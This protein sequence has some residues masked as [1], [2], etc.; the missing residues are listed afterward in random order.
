MQEL[1]YPLL[2]SGDEE[3][4]KDYHAVVRSENDNILSFSGNKAFSCSR[5]SPA[6]RVRLLRICYPPWQGLYR[7][8]L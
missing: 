8:I 3:A 4:H 6:P 1:P 7:L 5:G 2:S